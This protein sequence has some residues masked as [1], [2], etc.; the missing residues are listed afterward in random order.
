M[1]KNGYARN[2]EETMLY[3]SAKITQ[4]FGLKYFNVPLF[5]ISLFTR[6][7]AGFNSG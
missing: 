5:R 7:S 6:Y 4:E 3:N 2:K 1:S